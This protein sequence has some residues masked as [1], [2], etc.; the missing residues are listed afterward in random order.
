MIK[1]QRQ[2]WDQAWKTRRRRAGITAF[3][4]GIVATL[5]VFALF[6]GLP[7]VIDWGAVLVSLAVGGLV[8]W[9]CQSWMT[10]TTDKRRERV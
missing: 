6:P 5:A 1:Q 9:I 3:L 10:R 2:D 8:R 4:I 7:H